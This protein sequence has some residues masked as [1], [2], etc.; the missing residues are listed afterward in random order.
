VLY[1]PFVVQLTME[2]NVADLHT[3]EEALH[4]SVEKVLK[5]V[6]TANTAKNAVNIEKFEELN[7]AAL[8]KCNKDT[9]AKLIENLTKSLISNIV[10]CKSAAGTIDYV[11][12]ELIKVQRE[13]LKSVQE[14]VQTEIKTEMKTWSEIARKN[15][16]NKAPTLKTV[17]K[18]VQSAVQ[19]DARSRNFIV[20]GVPEDYSTCP[21]DLADEVLDKIL[22]HN[23]H[24]DIVAAYRIGVKKRED[25]RPRPIKVTMNSNESVKEALSRANHL[26][27]SLCTTYH[28]WFVAPDRNREEQATHKKLVAQLKEKI[29]AEPSKYHYIKDGKVLSVVNAY[30]R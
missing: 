3:Q 19:D 1:S 8:M 4:S 17:K 10:L 23:N 28:S 11:K 9:M 29:S 12:S 15:C 2:F 27:K 24:S 7:H 25:G 18:A 13:Q 20:H 6:N 22:Q 26:K 5:A 30:K 16:D 21:A 14:T